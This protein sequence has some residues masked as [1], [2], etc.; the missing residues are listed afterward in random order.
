M[1]TDLGADAEAGLATGLDVFGAGL[2]EIATV[3]GSTE[4][5]VSGT[6][7][8]IR[9]DIYGGGKAGAV[10]GNTVVNATNLILDGE[11]F[12]GGLGTTARVGNSASNDGSTTVNISGT[13]TVL[14]K[15]IYG[16]GSAGPVY[17][18][19]TVT[20]PEG[21]VKQNVFG[22]GLEAVVTGNTNVNVSGGTAGNV[23]G[24]GSEGNVDGVATVNVT[25]AK[26][27]LGN[28]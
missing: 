20:M 4:V 21:E 25:N 5:N 9:A 18:N 15:N 14:K 10:D 6:S 26:E 13:S 7:T 22:G 1:A 12:G 19:T 11:I 8:T 23:Y 2:G 3:S 24:G 17:G 28:I 27:V 16:G